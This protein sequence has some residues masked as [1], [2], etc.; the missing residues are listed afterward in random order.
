MTAE[1]W[2]GRRPSFAPGGDD[3]I[4]DSAGYQ[5]REDRGGYRRPGVKEDYYK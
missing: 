1:S 2:S 3:E 5:Q 4:N